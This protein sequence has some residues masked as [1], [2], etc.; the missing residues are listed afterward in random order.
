[1]SNL[2]VQVAETIW[3]KKALEFG[4]F[5]L[6]I[7]KEDKNLPLSPFYLNLRINK[8]PKPGPLSQQDLIILAQCLWEKI[9]NIAP[10]F[11][12][13]A[14]IPNAGAYLD[15]ALRQIIPKPRGFFFLPLIKTK[16]SFKI[17]PGFKYS[18]GE[19]VV[20]IDDVITGATTK[21]QAIKI[22][23]KAGLKVENIF[24]V[25][26]RL[27]GGKQI[28]EQKGY[29]VYSCFSIHE[30]LTYYWLQEYIDDK[31]YLK[32]ENY[33]RKVKIT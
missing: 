12:L 9:V 33:L 1:M 15:Q 4:E 21:L 30:L 29:S 25:I 18:Q 24:V 11:S 22:I 27:Q 7:N 17:Q 10:N 26:N 32:C 28:L 2:F 13:L 19:N 3:Q 20:L 16:N 23:E 31:I 8:G 5:E 6:K 14:G